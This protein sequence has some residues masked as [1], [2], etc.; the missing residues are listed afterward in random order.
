M[1]DAIVEDKR[2]RDKALRSVRFVIRRLA[3]WALA[4]APASVQRRATRVPFSR[5]AWLVPVLFSGCET[6][7]W[8][9][10][11]LRVDPGETFGYFMYFCGDR[12]PDPE[13]DWLIAHSNDARI[14]ADVGAHIGM[15]A[16][17]IAARRPS[18]HVT[19][20]EASPSIA[21]RLRENLALNPAVASRIAVVERAVASS[22]GARDFLEANGPN[23]GVGRLSSEAD[24]RNTTAICVPSITLSQ[25]FDG[26]L[27]PDLV[28]I[29]VEG[30]E[31]DVL[32]GW[33]TL[34]PA[35]AMA[36]ELHQPAGDRQPDRRPEVVAWLLSRGY[37]LEYLV[38][39]AIVEDCPKPMPDRL[40]VLAT[41][42]SRSNVCVSAAAAVHTR[43]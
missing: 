22:T 41:H 31:L 37:Q 27:P 28:K 24:S 19:A 6:A 14:F 42:T 25:H 32:Q 3:S 18:L 26:H 15:Y 33:G 11:T 39:E 40:H 34:P 20:F 17:A 35:K 38:G 30:A 8:R 12:E 36:V 29:D 10:I 1:M 9:G 2:V 7:R 16:M 43:H 13:F 4:L 21:R 5:L 23:S